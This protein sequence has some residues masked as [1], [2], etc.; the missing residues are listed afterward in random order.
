[1]V[2]AMLFAPVMDAIA[3]SLATQSDVSPATVTF[4]RFV[5]QS[6]FLG[7]FVAIAWAKGAMKCAFSWVNILRGMI[8]GLLL[9]NLKK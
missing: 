7:L 5:V 1:M 9:L 2:G 4:G 8:M 3:K 6:I